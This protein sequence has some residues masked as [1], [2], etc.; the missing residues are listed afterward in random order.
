LEDIP[1]Y[2]IRT[3]KTY[4]EYIHKENPDVKTDSILEYAGISKYELED[5]GHWL[6]QN[7]VNRFHEKMDALVEDPMVARNAGRYYFQAGSVA[8]IRQYMLSFVSPYTVFSAF[9]KLTSMFTR[10]TKFTVNRSGN[11]KIE[12]TVRPHSGIKE[13]KFQCENRMGNLEAIMK[14]YTGSFSSVEHPECV[15][16]G[17]DC[18]KYIIT[19]EKSYISWRIFQRLLSVL[20]IPAG[21]S[22]SSCRE[23]PGSLLSFSISLFSQVF[24]SISSI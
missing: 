19:L 24:L 22:F 14:V 3:I 18:C 23:R 17:D 21:I 10:S 9:E 1:L 20:V 6:T 2:S 13:K 5:D 7:Q 11:N 16:E 15:H 4:I 12:I 8:S